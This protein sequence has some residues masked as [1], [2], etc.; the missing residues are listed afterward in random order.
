RGWNLIG[1][2]SPQKMSGGGLEQ[3]VGGGTRLETES[4]LLRRRVWI[5]SLQGEVQSLSQIDKLVSRRHEN[6][7][8][9]RS[10]I[11]RFWGCGW[12]NKYAAAAVRVS[13]HADVAVLWAKRDEIDRN[14]VAGVQTDAGAGLA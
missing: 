11:G 1:S 8:E 7:R 4:Q 14:P 12:Q 13:A 5:R 6:R 3:R 2:G 9:I 10:G